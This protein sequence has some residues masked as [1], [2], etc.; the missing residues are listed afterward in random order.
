MGAVNLVTTRS[1]AEDVMRA[2]RTPGRAWPDSW[3][4]ASRSAR[5]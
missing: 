2:N 5:N 4:T 1:F 3:M